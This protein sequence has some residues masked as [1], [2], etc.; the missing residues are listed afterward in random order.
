MTT[1][2][3]KGSE[4]T[5]SSL[6]IA[7]LTGKRHDHVMRDIRTMLD[8]LGINGP[9]FG[10]VYRDAKNEEHPLFLLP[11]TETVILITGYSIPMRAAVVRRLKTATRA[12]SRNMLAPC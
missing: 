11:K 8:A 3:A 6:E 9:R 5:M 10:G 1:I 12:P 2:Q 7:E 4:P